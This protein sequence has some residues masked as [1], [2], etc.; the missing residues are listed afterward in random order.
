MFC[1]IL[2][3][4]DFSLLAAETS[5]GMGD[6]LGFLGFERSI[7]VL[8]AFAA[9]VRASFVHWR[10]SEKETDDWGFFQL[11]LRETRVG[12]IRSLYDSMPGSDQAILCLLFKTSGAFSDLGIGDGLWGN[13]K[14]DK[15]M[16]CFESIFGFDLEQSTS[17][18]TS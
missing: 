7:T 3:F 11:S 5:K 16:S 12:F 4:S 13:M 15:M 17:R 9:A 1:I 2:C 10:R 18:I 8:E 14:E 6:G